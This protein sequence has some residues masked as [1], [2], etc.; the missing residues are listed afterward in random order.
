MH[1]EYEPRFLWWELFEM[2]RGWV[3]RGEC[4]DPYGEFLVREAPSVAKEGLTTE[5][6]CAYWQKRFT[7]APAQVRRYDGP[8]TPPLPPTSPTSDPTF[9]PVFRCPSSSSRSPPRS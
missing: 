3:Y 8:A 5:Y 9:S 7:L 4:D 1:A 6:A 2:L